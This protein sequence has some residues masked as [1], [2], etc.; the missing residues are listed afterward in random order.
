M[1][2]D[3]TRNAQAAAA[4]HNAHEGKNMVVR[5]KESCSKII[6]AH[7]LFAVTGGAVH[8]TQHCSLAA[9]AQLVSSARHT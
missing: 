7:R 6:A 3:N 5:S 1:R 8:W 9:A 2:E 4:E